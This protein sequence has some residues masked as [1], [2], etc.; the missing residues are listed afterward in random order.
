MVIKNFTDIKSLS[1]DEVIA[2][3]DRAQYYADAL[4]NG[5]QYAK[6]LDGKIILTMFFENST[7][8]RSSF[9]I[10][11]HRLG[12][13]IVN[14]DV[15]TSS[16]QKGESFLDTIQT[17]AAM[18]PDAV[19]MRHSEYDAPAAVVPHVAFPVVNAGDSWRAHPSQALLDALTMRQ[20]CGSLDGLSVAICGDIAHSRVASS[21]IELLSRF[22]VDL[23]LVAPP[24]LQPEP[25]KIT[26]PNIT[27]YDDFE[28]GIKGAD[29]IIMLRIQ[30]ERMESGMIP[31]NEEYFKHWGL[32]NARLDAA[33]PKAFVMHPGPMNRGVEIADDVADDPR[34]SLVRK[35]VSNGI[36]ARMAILDMLIGE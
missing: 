18:K 6:R 33:N 27:L 29:V 11:V 14:W 8:T 25:H 3:L 19:V 23:R 26:N 17:L 15:K 4:N 31:S 36:P 9:E 13:N 10:A 1:D 35:Q 24:A 7:R 28:E 34:R 30:R 12:G 32:T 21:N 16:L 22:A 2:L 5:T 20:V